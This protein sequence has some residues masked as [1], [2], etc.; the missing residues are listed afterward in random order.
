MRVTFRRAIPASAHCDAPDAMKWRRFC[1][2]RRA[3]AQIVNVFAL[4]TRERSRRGDPGKEENLA[5]IC[6]GCSHSGD[7]GNYG[8]GIERAPEGTVWSR[9]RTQAPHT[10]L[11]DSAKSDE[12]S[13]RPHARRGRLRRRG[14]QCG[15]LSVRRVVRRGGW[16]RQLGRRGCEL[17]RWGGRV[18]YRH[19]RIRR[20]R[21]ELRGLLERC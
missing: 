19:L 10:S 7:R 1:A 3:C 11:D 15:R 20:T 14:L 18:E 9:Y 8:C 4:K 16:R 2:E 5:R 17:Y 21:D 13:D 6:R 12:R